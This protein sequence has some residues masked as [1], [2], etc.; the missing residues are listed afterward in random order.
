MVAF[1]KRWPVMRGK[2]NMICK[3]RCMKMGQILQLQW[4]FPGPSRGVPLYCLNADHNSLILVALKP[5]CIINYILKMCNNRCICSNLDLVVY[6]NLKL[7]NWFK[8]ALC[9]HYTFQF[10]H[11]SMTK[12]SYYYRIC[13]YAPYPAWNAMIGWMTLWY[14]WFHTHGDKQISIWMG[15]THKKHDLSLQWR[16]NG[17][18]G[19]SNDQLHHCFTQPFIQVQIKESQGSHSSWKIIEIQICFKIMERSLNFMKSA[20]NL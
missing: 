1:Q 5:H 18:D 2:I 16:H 17:R 7:F 14:T 12:Q 15:R 9:L 13:L 11:I 6:Q 4:D 3:E 10:T 19:V 8:C 20:W